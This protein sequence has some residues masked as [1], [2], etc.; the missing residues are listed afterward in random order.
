MQNA[1]VSKAGTVTLVLFIL[2]NF[3]VETAHKKL[4]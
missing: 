2:L 1:K 4:F 3:R